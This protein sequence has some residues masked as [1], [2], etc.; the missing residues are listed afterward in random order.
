MTDPGCLP[1]WLSPYFFESGSLVEL[2]L[3]P[4]NK[5]GWSGSTRDLFVSASPV[6]DAWFLTWVVGI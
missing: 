3:H 6:L 4:F 5:P 1:Q 2:G